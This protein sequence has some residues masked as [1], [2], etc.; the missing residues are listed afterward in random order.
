M[1][2][3]TLLSVNVSTMTFRCSTVS[4][5]S[6]FFETDFGRGE[7]MSHY[8]ILTFHPAPFPIAAV[9]L[10]MDQSVRTCS[11]RMTPRE[12]YSAIQL[13]KV[14]LHVTD[15]WQRGQILA[16]I[17]VS[18]TAASCLDPAVK[19]QCSAHTMII[20]IVQVHCVDSA[21]MV[22]VWGC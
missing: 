6:Q 11:S 16:I 4:R 12:T 21:S 3:M 2:A 13:G 22:P 7:R 10:V 8:R 5:R 15:L 1:W 14:R 20:T 17:R 9:T 18:L 19:N